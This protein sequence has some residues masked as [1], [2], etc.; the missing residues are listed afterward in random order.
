V[1]GRKFWSS[2]C[3]ISC[4][5]CS[6]SPRGQSTEA[7]GMQICYFTCIETFCVEGIIN[8]NI[9]GHSHSQSPQ[10]LCLAGFCGHTWAAAYQNACAGGHYDTNQAPKVAS[11]GVLRRKLCKLSYFLPLNYFY[12]VEGKGLKSRL[13]FA[14]DSR[15]RRLQPNSLITL[16][17][18][19]GLLASFCHTMKDDLSASFSRALLSSSL[20]V[21]VQR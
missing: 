3:M 21:P 5:C 6:S 13:D 16:M 4:F 17:L 15:L 2:R 1:F 12:P 14:E 7:L 10:N 20:Q 18:P 8:G 9:Q 19:I 11:I